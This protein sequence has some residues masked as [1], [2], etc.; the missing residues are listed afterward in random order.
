MTA[1]VLAIGAFV[2]G[3]LIG[4][5]LG[6]NEGWQCAFRGSAWQGNDDE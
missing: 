6:Y 3:Y 2:V 4:R 1:I 5:F